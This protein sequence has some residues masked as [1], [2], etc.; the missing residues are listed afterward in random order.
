[1]TGQKL[2]EEVVGLFFVVVAAVLCLAS[3]GVL[4]DAVW[5]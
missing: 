5:L 3:K 1:M 4:T 2:V